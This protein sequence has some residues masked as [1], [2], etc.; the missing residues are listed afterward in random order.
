VL[1]Q[2]NEVYDLPAGPPGFSQDETFDG[3][4]EVS[5]ILSNPWNE[6]G[7]VQILYLESSDVG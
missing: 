5:E 7:D 3:R 4:E 6:A 1:K 2:S